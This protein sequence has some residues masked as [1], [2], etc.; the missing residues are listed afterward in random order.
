MSPESSAKTDADVDS[1]E[2]WVTASPGAAGGGIRWQLTYK[3]QR[4]G[5]RGKRDG[6]QGRDVPLEL[7]RSL[8]GEG[9]LGDFLVWLSSMIADGRC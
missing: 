2:L 5:W 7:L 8:S 4:T 6:P 3:S 9:R 1:A